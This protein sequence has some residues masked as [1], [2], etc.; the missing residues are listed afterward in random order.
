MRDYL[1]VDHLK[2]LLKNVQNT[3]NKVENDMF[4]LNVEIE[5][6]RLVSFLQSFNNTKY[7]FVRIN[8]FMFWH[9]PTWWFQILKIKAQSSKTYL[10]IFEWSEM[11]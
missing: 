4:F 5:M 8:L 1:F 11:A 3:P 10:K 9:G 2:N 7:I 6:E